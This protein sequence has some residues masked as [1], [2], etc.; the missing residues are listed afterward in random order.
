[1]DNKATT[2]EVLKSAVDHGA[3]TLGEKAG[4]E[5]TNLKAS[6]T[7]AQYK[8][9]FKVAEVTAMLAFPVVGIAWA[10]EQ[11]GEKIMKHK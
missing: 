5:V 1:M 4:N 9:I 11:A 8:E 3:A 2:T 7:P 6:L 10:A